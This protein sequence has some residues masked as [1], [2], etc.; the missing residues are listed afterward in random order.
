MEQPIGGYHRPVLLEETLAALDVR[1]DGTY[2]DGTAGGGRTCLCRRLP[3]EKR[4]ADRPGSGSRRRGR[5]VG[6]PAGAAR[7]GGAF[8]FRRYAGGAPSAL[9]LGEWTGSCWIS[10]F[11]PI[12]SIPRKRVFLSRRRAAGHADEQKRQDGGGS[13]SRP[14]RTGTRRA[15]FPI[16]GGTVCPP[17]RPRHCAGARERTGRY[18]RRLGRT[19]QRGRSGNGPAGWASRPPRVQALRIAV[20]GELDRLSEGLDAAFD[21]LNEG[22]TAG[23]DYLSFFGGPDGQAAFCRMAEGAAPARPTS[24]FASAGGHRRPSRSCAVP[25]PPRSGS[26]RRIPEAAVPSCGASESVM[27]DIGSV[28]DTAVRKSSRHGESQRIR[29]V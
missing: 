15:L 1:P 17:H 12:S 13:H 24:R 4:A 6:A 18:H 7:D 2:L 8:Q 11:P 9:G 26:W 22:W 3:T 25:R 28:L 5:G 23:G 20:N 29:S 16:R 21:C 19:G 10:G 27:N 14:A